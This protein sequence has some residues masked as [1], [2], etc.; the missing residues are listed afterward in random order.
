[1]DKQ[2]ENVKWFFEEGCKT[3]NKLQQVEYLVDYCG[4]SE[5]GAFELIYGV[6]EADESE[7]SYDYTPEDYCE[8]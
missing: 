4:Y 6:V 7:D 3:M 5:D 2:M 8:D 1:M